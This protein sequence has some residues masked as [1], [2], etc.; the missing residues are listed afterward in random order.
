M[1]WI[2]G[3]DGASSVPRRLPPPPLLT[4]PSCDGRRLVSPEGIGESCCD[5]A[6]S[7]ALKIE[8]PSVGEGMLPAQVGVQLSPGS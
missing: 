7:A 1:G 8:T 2:T 3:R 5:C 6:A 4:E